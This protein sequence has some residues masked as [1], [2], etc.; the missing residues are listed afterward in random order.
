[1]AQWYSSVESPL[2]S[3]FPDA[4]CP[5]AWLD[6][7]AQGPDL[8]VLGTFDKRWNF[9]DFKEEWDYPDLSQF[10]AW[11]EERG[12]SQ[13]DNAHKS[14]DRKEEA[15]MPMTKELHNRQVLPTDAFE[16]KVAQDWQQFMPEK[17]RGPMHKIPTPA[18]A[19]TPLCLS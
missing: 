17:R 8:Q 1:M 19:V 10:S 2:S 12:R 5:Y 11:C 9:G 7:V 14:E 13:K 3:A 18:R 15:R 6:P 4:R 16:A